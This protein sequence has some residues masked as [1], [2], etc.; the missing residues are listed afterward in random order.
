MIYYMEKLGCATLLC[1]AL[2]VYVASVASA[3]ARDITTYHYDNLRTGWNDRET[4]LKP[5]NVA[6]S[7]FGILAS[8]IMDSGTET[9]PLIATGIDIAGGA[10]DVVYVATLSNHV[11][12][13]DAS[14][15]EQLLY[16]NL[17]DPPPQ[18]SLPL[19][20][21]I[22]IESGPVIDL[23]SQ[24]LF[25]ITYT[26]E[27]STPT[28]RLHALDLATLA[29]KIPS[30]VVGGSNTLANGSSVQFEGWAQRQRPALLLSLGNVYAA[31]GS[32]GDVDDNVARGWVLGWNAQTLQPLAANEITNHQ[33]TSS[34]RCLPNTPSPCFLSTVWMSGFGLAADGDGSIY[35]ATG[36]SKAGSYSPTSNLAESAV[37]LSGDLST[38]LGIFTPSNE[39]Q[40]DEE[41]LDLGSG[42][43]TLIPHQ[44]GQHAP[45]AVVA[46]KGGILYLLDRKNMGGSSL[47]L[48][49][50]DFGEY[51]VGACYCGQSYFTGSDGI[52]RLVTSAGNTVEVWQI[53]TSPTT[54]LTQE[55]QSSQ[56][57]SGQDGGFFT[58]VS[59]DGTQPGTAII[60]AVIRPQS[61]QSG[62][63]LYAL[64]ASDG[65]VLY[66]SP[67]GS[68]PNVNYNAVI[69]PV[70]A[71]GK[72][73]VAAGATLVILGLGAT[74]KLR[75]PFLD[76]DPAADPRVPGHEIYGRLMHVDGMMLTLQLRTGRTVIVD[77]EWAQHIHRCAELHV[78]QAFAADGV[79]ENNQTMHANRI[80]RAKASPSLWLPDK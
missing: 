40:L 78:G 63:T 62:V 46:G 35:F 44:P 55:Y 9:Q 71:N 49:D 64:D 41:G 10:H 77:S 14:T 20:M 57:Q 29:D 51:S 33:T 38:V 50:N 67:A 31:F 24:T 53:I 16:V 60:W 36:N 72:V 48:P 3:G 47:V 30:V 19:P 6:S 70:V 5:S 54:Q 34:G 23:K 4:V 27:N 52:G 79:W 25:L 45:L 59:S 2:L 22:G 66:S 15:G 39:L 74:G 76:P 1:A 42:G 56:F 18:S 26:S 17:G 69:V 68:W 58:T 12:A 43:V 61:F 13:F 80:Y 21:T 73:Y 37:K 11:Y 32:F 28:Y 7:S 75:V 65:T 8:A